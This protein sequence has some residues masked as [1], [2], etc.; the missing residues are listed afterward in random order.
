VGKIHHRIIV[1]KNERMNIKIPHIRV[2]T[3]GILASVL[4]S[5]GLSL[6]I[7]KN[8]FILKT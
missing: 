7:F 8:R 1:R 4:M 2:L 5:H 6:L 3:L